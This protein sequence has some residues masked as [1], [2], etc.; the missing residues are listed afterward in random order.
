[1]QE[2]ID[3]IRAAT[4]PDATK[5]QKGAA[6]QACRTIAAALDTD[7]GHPLPIPA[8]VSITPTGALG[9]LSLDQALDLVIARLRGIADAR[10]KQ[11]T[12]VEGP[13]TSPP[14]PQLPPA[15]PRS[16]ARIPIATSDALRS[17]PRAGQPRRVSPPRKP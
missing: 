15:A 11:T 17:P 6:V 5:E 10:D 14:V 8:A 12:A 9:R 13:S 2:L 1:M 4:A 16:R 7:P 3:A